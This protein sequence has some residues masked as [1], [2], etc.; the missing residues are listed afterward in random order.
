MTPPACLSNTSTQR[1]APVQAS[2]PLPRPNQHGCSEVL[3]VVLHH[4]ALQLVAAHRHLEAHAVTCCHAR[5]HGNGGLDE[6]Q[7][8][9]LGQGQEVLELGEVLLAP[10]GRE[11]RAGVED[12]SRDGNR[13]SGACRQLVTSERGGGEKV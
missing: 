2:C 9:G 8:L 11:G 6:H 10:G 12:R 1:C 3:G 4:V 13:V 5:H 7:V